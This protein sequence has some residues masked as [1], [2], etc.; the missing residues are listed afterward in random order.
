MAWVRDTVPVLDGQASPAQYLASVWRET[1][2]GEKVTAVREIPGDIDLSQWG[3]AAA[4]GGIINTGDVEI[5][6]AGAA[7]VRHYVT[8]LQLRNANATA[9]E[10][11]IKDGATV[12]WRTD[13]PANMAGSME[14]PFRTPLK[15]TAATALNVA[16]ITTGAKV[17]CN[18]QGFD[19]P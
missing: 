13:L 11:V 14:V 19:A 2:T 5:R 16:C 15:G 18:M 4:S 1:V 7:G 8:G 17:Y 12:I 10:F 6:A 9:T 3:Y